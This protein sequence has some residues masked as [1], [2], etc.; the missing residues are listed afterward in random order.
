M[1]GDHALAVLDNCPATT[2]VA[3]VGTSQAEKL[4]KSPSRDREQEGG[5]DNPDAEEGRCPVQQQ[6]AEA[7]WTSRLICHETGD[8]L[9]TSSERKEGVSKK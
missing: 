6:P 8:E 3:E 1:R 5:W 2:A 7:A 9:W 4:L